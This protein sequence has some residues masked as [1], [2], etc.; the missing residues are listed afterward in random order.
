MSSPKDIDLPD[1]IG[2]SQLDPP[3]SMETFLEVSREGYDTAYAVNPKTDQQPILRLITPDNQ[4]LVFYFTRD[5]HIAIKGFF[6]YF[7]PHHVQEI[8]VNP[9]KS[10]SGEHDWQEQHHF[11]NLIIVSCQNC[12]RMK[13]LMSETLVKDWQNKGII[14]E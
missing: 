4:V 2:F 13:F 7:N 10:E 5:A 6:L 1:V 3:P 12:N 9:C 14:H 8:K 11:K